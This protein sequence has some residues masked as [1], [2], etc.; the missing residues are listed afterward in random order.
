MRAPCARAHLPSS[1]GFTVA[2]A[3]ICPPARLTASWTAAGALLRFS[4]RANSATVVSGGISAIAGARCCSTSACF[5]RSTPSTTI[6]RRPI[7]NVI[8]LSAS[9]T[10]AGAPA[11]PSS[12]STLAASPCCSASAFKPARRSATAPWS[13]PWIR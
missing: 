5:Q 2:C 11:S 3:T 4:S 6:T 1:H 13:S 9:A 8:A 7:A 12:T 10:P